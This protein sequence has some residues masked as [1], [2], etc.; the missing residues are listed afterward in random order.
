MF[1]GYSP[2]VV[3]DA[4][5]ILNDLPGAHVLHV[6]RNPWSAYAD[7]KKRPVPLSLDTYMLGWTLNQHFALLTRR[8][9]PDRMH[10]VRAE[11]VMREPA[12]DARLAARGARSRAGR[13]ARQA[14]LER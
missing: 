1:V 8:R 12:R 4:E 14:E 6:V 11:D 3:V 13:R 7:T 10:I 9:F 5:K 2:V